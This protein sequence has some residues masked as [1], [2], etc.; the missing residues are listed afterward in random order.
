PLT[1][2]VNVAPNTP[3]GTY[4]VEYRIEDKLNPGQFKTASVTITVDAPI[5]VANNDTGSANGFTGGEAVANVLAND[6]YNGN[7]ATLANV[8]LTQVSSTNTNVSL[9]PLTGKVNVA[10]NTPAGTYT[11]EYCIE[12]KLNPGQFKTASVTVTVTTGTITAVND[13]GSAN[14]FDGGVAVANV[15]ANDT[16]NGGNPANLGNVSINQLSTNNSN[17]NIDVTTGTVNVA[18]G[19][20]PGTYTLTY[21]IVD[22]LDASKKSNATITIVVPEWITDLSITKTANKTGVEVNENISYTITIRNNGPASVLAGK[23]FGLVENIP[24]GLDNIIYTANGGTYNATNQTFTVATNVLA[25]QTVSLVVEGKINSAYAQNNIANTATVN[26]AT[27]TSDPDVAN[28]TS[29]ITTPILK[30]KITLVKTG[31]VSTDGNSITYTFTISNTGNVA[32]N[33][34]TLVDAKL[35]LNKVLPGILAIGASITTTEVYMLSQADKDLGSV[36]NTASVNSKSPAGNDVVDVSGTDASNDTPTVITLSTPSG[37]QLT[38]VAT[39][40][41]TKVGDVIN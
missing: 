31:V 39:N 36:T 5:I 22:K 26:V 32:L 23:T 7:P 19:T 27:G 2:K 15:L 12:D 11:V 37:L 13:N 4:T 24:V 14:G 38:K 6:T 33:N 34:I 10:P 40:T 21:E 41:V 1:G 28:N 25:G 30:G 29:T 35:G 17:I 9:D 16:Y 18:S 3:A 8:N 20:L